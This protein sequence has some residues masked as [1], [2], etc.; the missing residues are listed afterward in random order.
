MCATFNEWSGRGVGGRTGGEHEAIK[1]SRGMQGQEPR[2]GARNDECVRELPGQKRDRARRLQPERAHPPRRAGSLSIT[3][4][5]VEKHV[6]A[7]F[8]KIDLP[9]SQAHHRRVLAVVTCL[10]S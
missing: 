3:E 10:N 1:P 6:S 5:A 2:L 7:I 9:P 4:R 8:T